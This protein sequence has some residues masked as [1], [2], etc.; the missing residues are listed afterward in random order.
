MRETTYDKA[1]QITN[2]GRAESVSHIPIVATT[3]RRDDD[4]WMGLPEAAEKCGIKY[5]TL[6]GLF[7]DYGHFNMELRPRSRKATCGRGNGW[8][9]RRSDFFLLRAICGEFPKWGATK[10]L[11]LFQAVKVGFFQIVDGE[12][13]RATKTA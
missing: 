6:S 1:I 11:E 5:P 10:Q 7:S 8:Q 13:C 3:L 4:Q 9:I 2:T 12:D